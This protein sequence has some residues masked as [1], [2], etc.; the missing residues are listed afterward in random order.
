MTWLE[1]TEARFLAERNRE[2]R[3][4]ELAPAAYALLRLEFSNLV[5][6]AQQI[7]SLSSISI[8]HTAPQRTVISCARE[9]DPCARNLEL[10]L[11]AEKD[12]HIYARLPS[13]ST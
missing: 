1:G 4:R 12:V 3:I 6:E 10:W 2:L 8:V 11:S 7:A 9:G 5:R 13:G